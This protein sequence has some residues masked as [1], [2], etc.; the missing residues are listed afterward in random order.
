[1]NQ[2]RSDDQLKTLQALGEQIKGFNAA[3]EDAGDAFKDLDG[4]LRGM[5]DASDLTENK[6]ESLQRSLKR[7][8]GVFSEHQKAM[9]ISD[10]Q[11]QKYTQAQAE[12]NEILGKGTSATEEEF[13]RLDTIMKTLSKTSKQLTGDIKLNVEA[14]AERRKSEQEALAGENVAEVLAAFEKSVREKSKDKDK[15]IFE[16]ISKGVGGLFPDLVPVMEKIGDN[17]LFQLAAMPFKVM[18]LEKLEDLRKWRITKRREAWIQ[19]KIRNPADE[20]NFT[21]LSDRFMGALGSDGAL[22][23]LLPKVVGNSFDS[24]RE[25]LRGLREDET[26]G[27]GESDL[28]TKEAQAIRELITQERISREESIRQHQQEFLQKDREIT[29]RSKQAQAQ[30]DATNNKTLEEM[31]VEGNTKLQEDIATLSGAA[32]I[33]DEEQLQIEITKLKTAFL[34]SNDGINATLEAE[35][36]KTRLIAEQELELER[37]NS[38]GSEEREKNR[39]ESRRATELIEQQMEDSAAHYNTLEGFMSVAQSEEGQ[40]V[41]AKMWGKP[42]LLMMDIEQIAEKLGL[43]GSPPYLKGL[44]EYMEKSQSKSLEKQT[45]SLEGISDNT[46][47]PKSQGLLGGL[48]DKG[49]GLAGPLLTGIAGFKAGG[50]KGGLSSLMGRGDTKGGEKAGGMLGGI[51]GMLGGVLKPVQAIASAG[52]SVGGGFVAFM[53]SLGAGL[54][55][56][57]GSIMLIPAPAL[58]IGAGIM[59]LLAAGLVSLGFALKLAA[60]FVEKVFGGIAKVIVS[61]GDVLAKTVTAISESFVKL[62]AIPFEAWAQMAGGLALLAPALLLLG[63]SALYAMPGLAVFSAFGLAFG[64]MVRLIGGPGAVM[65]M[66][67]GFYHLAGA[68]REFSKSSLGLLWTIPIFGALSALPVVGKLIDLAKVKAGEGATRNT[69]PTLQQGTQMVGGGD[70]IAPTTINNINNSTPTTNIGIAKTTRD[71]TFWNSV[72]NVSMA[73]APQV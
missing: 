45:E 14:A 21:N 25:E 53:T 70:V 17:T 10:E 19:R 8:I 6:V 11:M 69:S 72:G 56:F 59:G 42:D 47:S 30:L 73:F 4:S 23:K 57:F 51:T 9:S 29:E 68:V 40:E 63:G 33:G 54:T 16:S 35:G 22:G 39:E 52:A 26:G 65:E 24:V 71:D 46:E 7:N 41:L 37:V 66:A 50:L 20:K 67:D 55:A 13:K 64:V 18:A 60:P 2:N 12:A 3:S 36:K 5:L 38:L 34:E 15:N 62:T 48:I 61:I 43:K 28:D 31:A 58:A 49:K 44:L 1:M 27:F 32:E